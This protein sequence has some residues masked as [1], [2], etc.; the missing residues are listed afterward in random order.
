MGSLALSALT[1]ILEPICLGLF[2]GLLLGAQLMYIVSRIEAALGGQTAEPPPA[3]PPRP[4]WAARASVDLDESDETY[5]PRFAE[6]EADVVAC[7]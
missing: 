1:G 4:H 5:E 2:V 3:L 7:H 6:E